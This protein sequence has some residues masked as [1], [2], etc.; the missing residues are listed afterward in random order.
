M[1]NNQMNNN[2]MNNNQVNNNQMNLSQQQFNM[3]NNNPNNNPNNNNATKNNN[4]FDGIV[5]P[6]LVY[7]NLG[8]KEENIDQATKF[9]KYAVSALQFEDVGAAI[10]NLKKSL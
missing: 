10:D 2:Q 4:E 7:S 1:N 8:V 5:A 9:A 6:A 3:Q